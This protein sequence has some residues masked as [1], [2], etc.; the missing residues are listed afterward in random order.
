MSAIVVTYNRPEVAI[1]RSKSMLF[2][3][4]WPGEVSEI[5]KKKVLCHAYNMPGLTQ[6]FTG[7]TRN[8]K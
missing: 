4:N 1:F 5:A 6:Y 8:E 7:S 3:T 2:Q